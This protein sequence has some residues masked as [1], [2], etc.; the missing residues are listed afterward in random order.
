MQFTIEARELKNPR[1]QRT[2][3][4]ADTADDAITQFVTQNA[5][6]L[7]HVSKPCEG[8]E[9]IATVRKDESVYLIR[10]YAD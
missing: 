8:R 2:T 6:E 4:E 7:M 5:S 9:S 10:V 3:V 1:S